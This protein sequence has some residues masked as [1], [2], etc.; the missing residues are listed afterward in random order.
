M[1]HYYCRHCMAKMGTLEQASLEDDQL[2]IQTLTTQEREEMISY[3][4]NGDTHIQAICEDCHDAYT[5]N[6]DLHQYDYLIH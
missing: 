1:I 2:G 3:D 4:L 5:K 6:P